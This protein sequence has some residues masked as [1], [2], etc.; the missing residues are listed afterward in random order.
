M[1]KLSKV[2][3]NICGLGKGLGENCD[4]FSHCLIENDVKI[5]NHVTIKSGSQI[6][7]RSRR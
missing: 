6:W 5:G 1:L 4:I 3:L 7:D 2:I